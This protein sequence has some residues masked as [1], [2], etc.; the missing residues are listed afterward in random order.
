MYN[1]SGRI[2][3][4]LSK[5]IPKK[6]GF[7][8]VR[9]SL[10]RQSPCLKKKWIIT[11]LDGWM[12]SSEGRTWNNLLHRRLALKKTGTQTIQFMF[13]SLWFIC[14]QRLK[15]NCSW[16]VADTST[17]CH[18]RTCTNGCKD[19][20][21]NT[22]DFLQQEPAFRKTTWGNYL[23][24]LHQSVQGSYSASFWNLCFM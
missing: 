23:E 6:H 8:H 20:S 16:N 15:K 2:V 24:A 18:W 4:V 11:C 5:E 17:E 21:K 14:S 9:G 12:W 7:N 10:R 19:D 3:D 22:E 1:Q 13:T